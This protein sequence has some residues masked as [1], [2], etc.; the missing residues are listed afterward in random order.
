MG[1]DKGTQNA[2]KYKASSEDG[3]VGAG[4]AVGRDQRVD[5]GWEAR[6]NTKVAAEEDAQEQVIFI[7]TFSADFEEFDEVVELTV[8]ITAYLFVCVLTVN[9][10]H[11][12]V[13]DRRVD[14]RLLMRAVFSHEKR[15]LVGLHPVE[16]KSNTCYIW[17]TM[18]FTIYNLSHHTTTSIR[19]INQQNNHI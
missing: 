11:V 6:I 17:I 8:D 13:W 16:Y 3:G 1:V 10:Y 2:G 12:V 18:H 15:S 14:E 9:G 4:V 19:F 5:D 7:G